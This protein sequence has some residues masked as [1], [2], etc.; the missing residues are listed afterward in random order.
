MVIGLVEPYDGFDLLRLDPKNPPPAP[1]TIQPANPELLQALA[2]DFRDHKFSIHRLI[3]TIMKSNAYQLSTRFEGEW[4][5]AYIPYYARRFARVLS[6]PEA[7]D[8]MAEATGTPFSFQ[9]DG[10]R[11][12]YVKQLTNPVLLQRAMGTN[13]QIGDSPENKDI[14]SFMQAFY[15]AERMMPPV[16]KDV[17]SPVQAMLMMSSPIVTKRVSAEGTT[18]VGNLLKS[19]KS[20]DEMIE[21]LFLASLSRRP[22]A[23]EVEVAKRLIGKEDKKKGTEALQWTLVNTTE[24]LVNH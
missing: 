18:R 10:K 14:Y 13:R 20:D 22:T 19:G 8:I 3:K 11:F 4:K 9:Q 7:V 17:S 12:D 23:D 5:P 2:E 24:F 1:W 16:N 6:G 15:Q 21:E